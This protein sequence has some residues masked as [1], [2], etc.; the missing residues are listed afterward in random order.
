MRS[1]KN[2]CSPRTVREIGLGAFHGCRALAAIRLPDGIKSIELS[3]F[4]NCYSLKDIV[5]P[6]SVRQIGAYAFENC[7]SLEAITL[8]D[9]MEFTDIRQLFGRTDLKK[10]YHR[11]QWH[12]IQ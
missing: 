3:T 5:I 1:L 7:R 12:N 4:C 10:Y 9:A 6:Q 8:P 2:N 11:G